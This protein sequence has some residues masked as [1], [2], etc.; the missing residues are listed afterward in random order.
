MNVFP[1]LTS[2]KWSTKPLRQAGDTIVEVLIVLA[3][4]SLAFSISSATATHGLAQSQ[5]AQEHSQAQS[6][7][8]GQL[9][10]LRE[11]IQK[12]GTNIPASGTFC[13]DQPTNLTHIVSITH[14]DQ[15]DTGYGA[16]NTSGTLYYASITPVGTGAGSYY[17][18]QVRWEGTGT[19]GTQKVETTYRISQLSAA[20]NSGI[21]LTAGGAQVV[22]TP[23]V[24]KPNPANVGTETDPSPGC[25]DTY[26]KLNHAGITIELDEVDTAT[27]TVI[28]VIGQKTT[29]SSET[30]LTFTA[31]VVA[32]NHS[33]KAKIVSYP[34]TVTNGIP[35]F[36]ACNT[37]T[38]PNPSGINTIIPQTASAQPR[39]SLLIAPHCTQNVSHTFDLGS[40]ADPAGTIGPG[41][42]MVS[43]A[44]DDPPY[45]AGGTYNRWWENVAT[46]VE[47]NA[48]QSE[49]PV[50][51]SDSVRN[52]NLPAYDGALSYQDVPTQG[53]HTCNDGSKS[54]PTNCNE[55]NKYYGHVTY[56]ANMV[57]GAH[58]PA[59]Y[60]ER[61]YE[62]Y[63]NGT[64]YGCPS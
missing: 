42:Y 19:L 44:Y 51:N 26:G 12:G 63:R 8:D 33:Y 46:F 23:Y 2:F 1:D 18:L 41:Y 60:G 35:D 39:I 4:L 62:H 13:L 10:L 32:D 34:G 49:S 20:A 5:N 40:Y 59:V 27:G 45:D 37:G 28:G 3:I 14:P 50:Y 7:L 16:C 36:S 52:S 6:V 61:P 38:Y 47:G 25:S 58:H 53:H 31:P 21:P 57:P 55:Y 30:S 64:V 9:E 17:D 15:L 48:G 22:V 29:T 11:A 54:P 56:S 43:A 24:A